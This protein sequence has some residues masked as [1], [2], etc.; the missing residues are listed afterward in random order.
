MILVVVASFLFLAAGLYSGH[1]RSSAIPSKKKVWETL[2]ESVLLL[3]IVIAV[4]SI[5]LF[6]IKILT[7]TVFWVTIVAL[8][9]SV[10]ASSDTISRE[11]SMSEEK[12]AM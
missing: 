6:Y 9:L 1:R 2:I 3:S 7:T 12:A 8:W 10:F 11:I 4:L 5:V